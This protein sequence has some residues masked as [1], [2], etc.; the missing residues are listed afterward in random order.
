MDEWDW[1]NYR[2]V[3]HQAVILDSSIFKSLFASVIKLED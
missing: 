1:K 3:V 2:N